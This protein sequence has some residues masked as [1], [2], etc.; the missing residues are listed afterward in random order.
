M[1]FYELPKDKLTYGPNQVGAM[2]DQST[3]ISQQLTLWDQKGSGVIRG[4]LIVIPVENSFLYIVP[5][6]LRAE[7]TNFPQLKRVIAATGD[8]VVM[9]PSLDGALSALFGG[10][11]AED[12]QQTGIKT[13]GGQA[14]PN[15]PA[16][17]STHLTA[18]G[19]ERLQ[20]LEAQKA[21]D[22]LR[23]LLNNPA[24]SQPAPNT[25]R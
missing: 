13:P 14:V 2:I 12:I 18:L 11:S 20:L 4:K 8:K 1:L 15:T 17:A 10:S 24:E 25:P 9:E 23:R 21:L 7:G 16:D 22:S 3:L 19:Q 5:L 6:Y